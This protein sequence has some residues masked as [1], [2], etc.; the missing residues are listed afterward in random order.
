[1]AKVKER[2]VEKKLSCL[3]GCFTEPLVV[4][5][6][7]WADSLPE[8][9][10]KAVVEERMIALLQAVRENREPTGTEAEACAYLYTAGLVA[11]MDSDWTEIYLYVASQ[12][13]ARHRKAEVPDDIKVEGLSNY[14]KGLLADLRGRIYRCRRRATE[15]MERAERRQVREQG[16]V[17]KERN[18]GVQVSFEDLL[19]GGEDHD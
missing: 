8:W 13:M 6:G 7:G 1:M 4:C 17:V 10:R 11:P 5:P 3:A 9:L 18:Q 12:V 16:Q 19:K 15:G 14:R 2:E